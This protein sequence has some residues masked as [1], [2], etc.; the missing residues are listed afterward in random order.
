[1]PTAL[2]TM[3]KT[4]ININRHFANLKKEIGLFWDTWMHH[5]TA[6]A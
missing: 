5:P 4:T 2:A 6:D 3:P 1:M